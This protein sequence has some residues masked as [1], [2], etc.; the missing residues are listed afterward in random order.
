MV[1]GD[2]NAKVDREENNHPYAGRNGLHKES[3]ENGYKLLQF[4]AAADMIIGGTIFT[5]NNIHK[6]TWRLPDGTTMNQID[7]VLI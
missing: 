3:N 1:L 4:A 7:H 2:C 5:H 6:G